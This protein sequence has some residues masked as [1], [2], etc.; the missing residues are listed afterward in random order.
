[1]GFKSAESLAMALVVQQQIDSQ[2]A[3]VAF[4]LNPVTGDSS[5]VLVEAVW[6]QGEGL[7]GGTISPHGWTVTWPL[8]P[9]VASRVTS[10][11]KTKFAC[12]PKQGVQIVD[13]T[14]AERGAPP[15]TDKQAL[16]VAEMALRVAASYGVPYDIEWA[17][18][19]DEIYL[20]QARPI[21][22]FS[23]NVLGRWDLAGFDSS[24]VLTL[25]MSAHAYAAFM[26]KTLGNSVKDEDLMRMFFCK[27]YIAS[28]LWRSFGRQLK[29]GRKNKPLSSV[30]QETVALVKEMTAKAEALQHEKTDASEV[31]HE[32]MRRLLRQ[33]D[34]FN[35]T[36]FIV[37]EGA[38]FA[39]KQCNVYVLYLNQKFEENF[40]IAS[41]VD[42]IN[43]AGEAAYSSETLVALCK[44]FSADS[45][46][47][48]LL[49][50]GGSLDRLKKVNPE[51]AQLFQQYVN[52]FFFM[53]NRDEDV[54]GLRWDE[55]ESTPWAMLTSQVKALLKS[56]HLENSKAAIEE[57]KRLLDAPRRA[58]VSRETPLFQAGLEEIIGGIRKHL[59]GPDC[60]HHVQTFTDNAH[61]LRALLHEKEAIH[62]V[63][64]VNNHRLRRAIVAA[65]VAA[66]LAGEEHRLRSTLLPTHPVF[67][68]D[69]T[70]LDSLF[71]RPHAE[72]VQMLKD[73]M[74]LKS[75]YQGLDAPAN[76][77][78]GVEA[79]STASQGATSGGN[80]VTEQTLKGIGCSGGSVTAI[81]C[82]CTDMMEAA[83]TMQKGNVIV[84]S[85]T[86]PSWS[87]LFSLCSAVVLVDGG[88]LSHAAVVARE[89]KIPCVVGIKSALSLNGKTI[90]VNGSKG[91]VTIQ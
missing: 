45:A 34:E 18:H 86:D 82:V 38:E 28:E 77:G 66:N 27:S 6:G 13:T 16:R 67:C 7:V 51:A 42:G 88:V 71:A 24:S 60:D 89:M 30:V 76:V 8:N 69:Y 70:A 3:G 22:S 29:K 12:I 81:A 84:T 83:K 39:E 61:A 62:V 15:L 4:S 79:H 21:T 72:Q 43:Y 2:A 5:Q 53:S 59:A 23:C 57:V 50:E 35:Q 17:R 68:L 64:C 44:A 40:S 20:L 41:L 73:A 74:L 10:E 65:V 36:S 63:Y 54:S 52:R 14:A 31:P 32:R 9:A 56:G 75:M 78:D 55:D 33:Q 11:Q 87:P 49:S 1:M 80:E 91:L 46:T 26:S 25:S 58:V 90:T 19:G 48:K 47:A 37:G 85:Y